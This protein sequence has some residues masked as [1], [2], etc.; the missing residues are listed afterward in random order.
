MIQKQETLGSPSNLVVN[1]VKYDIVEDPFIVPIKFKKEVPINKN[2]F[3]LN[4][5]LPK[6]YSQN[7]QK[8]MVESDQM[9]DPQLMDQAELKLLLIEKMN[10]YIASFSILL[11][12]YEL[13]WMPSSPDIE[14]LQ[15]LQIRWLNFSVT[16]LLMMLISV[17][18]Y[19]HYG[20]NIA[21]RKNANL[22]IISELI[23]L[24][25]VMLAPNPWIYNDSDILHLTLLLRVYF[26]FTYSIVSSMYQ[27][28]RAARITNLYGIKPKN[29][30][31]FAVKVISNQKSI[32]DVILIYLM[33]VIFYSHCMFIVDE[34]L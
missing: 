22:F 32:S 4:E 5:P 10:A 11:S 18:A 14:T 25:I 9:H 31:K 12:L 23:K 20:N 24:L 34:H 27:D 26:P 16:I 1:S 2:I 28:P 19:F 33:V 8:K 7:V 3:Q 15:L 21:R 17:G 13:Y 30:F 6:N 29:T